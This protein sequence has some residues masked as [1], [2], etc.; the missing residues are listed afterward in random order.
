[1]TPTR[2]A[3]G[4]SAAGRAGGSAAD[5][6]VRHA[7]RHERATVLAT[8]ARRLGD[9][10]L[11]EDAVQEAFAVAAAR[12]AADGVP[13]RSGAWLTT[14]AWRKALDR[15]RRDHFPVPRDDR[16]GRPDVTARAATAGPATPD[17]RLEDD[18]VDPVVRHDDVLSLVLTCCHPALAPDAQIALTL[19]HVVGLSDR[20]IAARFLVPEP[21]MTK[22]LVRARAKIRDARISF[23]LPDRTRLRER[24]DEVHT[25]IYLIFTEGYLAADDGPAVGGELCE[26][27]LWLARQVHR[28]VPEDTETTGLL[29]LLLL[30]HARAAARQDAAGRLIPYDQQDRGL[31]DTA[32]VEQGKALLASTA[33][34]RGPAASPPDPRM[35]PGPYQL[36]AAIALL[37]TT[38]PDGHDPDWALIADLYTALARRSPSPVVEVNRAV[39]LGRAH[40]PRTGLEALRPALA[41]PRLRHYLPLHAAHADLL[42]RAGDP[43]ATRIWQRAADLAGN[44]AQRDELLRRARTGPNPPPV[45]TPTPREWHLRD[46]A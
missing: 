16:D 43:T 33:I 28:L 7:W 24:L 41:D 21:T 39:A 6:A 44:A 32:A 5:A 11:A 38:A 46:P 14:T 12:W 8:V 25:V 30:H 42:E 26:E 45:T 9:L 2:A 36:Q 37:H 31:W 34:H 13:H 40:D 4:G 18:A 27:A 17:P 19:R 35:A 15:L 1:M 22:R 23:A 20:Q 3:T 10:Q 29:A